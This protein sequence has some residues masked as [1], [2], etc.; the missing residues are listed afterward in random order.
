[1]SPEQAPSR[2]S[3]SLPT[4][5]ARMLRARHRIRD[6]LDGHIVEGNE[7]DAVVLAIEEA[8]TN[9]V[10]HSGTREDLEVALHVER[11]D[12]VARVK[13][14]GRGFDVETYVVE[15]RTRTGAVRMLSLN[16]D[17]VTI[18]GERHVLTTAQDVTGEQQMRAELRR[19][20]EELA[21]L[22]DELRGAEERLRAAHED[23]SNDDA[24]PANRGR[25]ARS[26]DPTVTHDAGERGGQS[27]AVAISPGTRTRRRRPVRRRRP[28]RGRS[29]CRRRRGSPRTRSRS[30]APAGMDGTTP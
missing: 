29:G 28:P 20:N 4:D 14:H 27:S 25:P 22:V 12:L 15:R 2:L 10:R 8:M 23:R 24:A 13:D 5:P 26:D 19:R 7:I 9:A 1:M 30:P 18:N 16:L 11:G 3:L 21:A 17:Y 6:Y